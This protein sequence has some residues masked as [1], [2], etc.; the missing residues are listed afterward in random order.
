MP[1]EFSEVLRGLAQRHGVDLAALAET[2]DKPFDPIA[3]RRGQ[4]HQ[5]LK[6]YAA[7]VFHP[8]QLPQMNPLVGKWVER[9][10]QDLLGRFDDP[11]V[12]MTA[13]WL[14]LYGRTGCGKSSQLFNVIIEL[15]LFATEHN[16][17]LTWRYVSHPEFSAQMRPGGDIEPEEAIKG[18]KEV[19]LLAFDDFGAVNAS[20]YAIDCAHRLVD[21]R[22]HRGMLT[23]FPSN[24]MLERTEGM[25]KLE[26]EGGP[27]MVVLADVLDPRT[28]SRLKAAWKVALPEVDYRLGSGRTLR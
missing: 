15:A 7:G 1:P 17:N 23:V 5:R 22:Y 4:V 27:R 18:Y 21:H 2:E 9:A 3:F 12:P 16:K 14:Y 6:Q 25:V 11:D 24:L 10:K 26:Q 19:D 13:P 20:P 8:D 28:V